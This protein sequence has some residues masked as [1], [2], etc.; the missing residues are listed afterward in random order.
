M[1]HRHL[2]LQLRLLLLLCLGLHPL[3]VESHL[4]LHQMCRQ[5]DRLSTG[6]LLLLL[7]VLLLLLLRLLRLLHLHHLL[8]C[9]LHALM[10]ASHSVLSGSLLL[11]YLLLLMAHT[12]HMLL[13]HQL[14]VVLHCEPRV[15]MLSAL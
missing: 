10:H 2:L 4:L 12:Q 8:W 15:S 5:L 3:L 6:L 1:L 13:L 7:L 9:E 14:R 11:E